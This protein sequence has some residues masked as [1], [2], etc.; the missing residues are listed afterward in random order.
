[1]KY[2]DRYEGNWFK[3]NECRLNKEER[4]YLEKGLFTFRCKQCKRKELIKEEV[5][6]KSFGKIYQCKSCESFYIPVIRMDGTIY[7]PFNY[8]TKEE[9]YTYDPNNYTTSLA[10]N[11]TDYI[12]TLRP[13]RISKKEA[14]DKMMSENY[15]LVQI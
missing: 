9:W 6:E 13:I 11:K 4:I 7:K 5:V 12:K 3:T 10:Y 14:F 2:K 1:V 8:N 15:E